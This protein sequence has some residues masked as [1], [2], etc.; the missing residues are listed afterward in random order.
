MQHASTQSPTPAVYRVAVTGHIDLGDAAA[1]SFVEHAFV[2]L[3][4]Q[5]KSEHPQGV[6]A[7]SGLAPGADTLF[8]EAAVRLELPFDVCI[9]NQAVLD[10][11][12]PGPVRDQHFRL[13][14]RSRL[15]HELPFAER[16][17]ESY[18]ALGHWLVDSCDVLIA[19]WNGLPGKKPGGTADVVAMAL[20]AE[21][22]VIHIH[23]QQ[24]AIVLL[25][26]AVR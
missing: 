5:Y 6:V 23:P 17:T 2:E 21:R 19:A 16:C 14:A 10:I 24:R 12:P 3:L 26:H 8:A 9:A 4:R 13:R 18:L 25:H 1:I 7:L 11:Y 15:V 22:P 20:A